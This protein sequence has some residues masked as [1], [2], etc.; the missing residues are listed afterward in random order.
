MITTGMG[1]RGG[2]ACSV[3]TWVWPPLFCVFLIST[4][5]T[6]V[7]SK[8][9]NYNWGGVNSNNHGVLASLE[10]DSVYITRFENAHSNQKGV[11][12]EQSTWVGAAPSSRRS[13]APVRNS[14]RRGRV[15]QCHIFRPLRI[16]WKFGFLCKIT[17]CNIDSA[18]F[19][20]LSIYELI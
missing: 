8:K 5:Y 15:W 14:H 7:Q 13:S 9:A 19:S 18:L 12:R 17:I 20:V 6:S 3:Q 16:G 11:V 4:P 1:R 2:G 10:K